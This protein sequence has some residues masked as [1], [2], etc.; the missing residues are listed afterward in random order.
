MCSAVSDDSSGLMKVELSL[1][2]L[3]EK[4]RRGDFFSFFIFVPLSFGC[5]PDLRERSLAKVL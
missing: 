5:W 4:H 3:Q 2:E 1:L